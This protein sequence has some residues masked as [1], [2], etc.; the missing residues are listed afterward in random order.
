[1]CTRIL[2]SVEKQ[3]NNTIQNKKIAQAWIRKGKEC[4][5]S[6]GAKFEDSDYQDAD[7]QH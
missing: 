6:A 3:V 4:E 7:Q 2:T 1:M 5:E